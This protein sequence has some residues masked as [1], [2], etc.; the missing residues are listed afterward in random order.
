MKIQKVI[1]QELFFMQGEGNSNA[2]V[3]LLSL[4][5]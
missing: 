3:G 2:C 1:V 4:K 5:T